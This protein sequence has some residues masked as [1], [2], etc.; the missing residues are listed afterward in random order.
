MSQIARIASVILLITLI[1]GCSTPEATLGQQSYGH[2]A[3]WPQWQGPTRDARSADTGLLKKWPEAGPRLLWHVDG[4]GA[5]YSSPTMA[6]GTI[7]ISGMIDKEGFITAVTMDGEVRWRKP[8]GPEW[9]RNYPGA[10][11]SV[12]IAD[13]RLF[14]LSGTGIAACLDAFTG[15]KKWTVDVVKSHN[16]RH[17]EWGYGESLLVV[18]SKV[19][20]TTG[21]RDGSLAALSVDDGR[22]LWKTDALDAKASYSSPIAVRRAGKDM[23][24]QLLF[25]SL[26]VVDA[27]NGSLMC[28]YDLKEHQ[29]TPGNI[30]V[31]ENTN[32]P[33]YEDGDIFVTSGY[34]AGS[35]KLRLSEDGTKLTKV[36]EN[37]DLDVH[38]GGVVLV[39]GHVYGTSWINNS[40]GRWVCVDWDT[41]ETR[42]QY[43]WDG[44]KGSIGYADG[45]LYCYREKTGMLALVTPGPQAF[46]VVSS[47]SV[48]TAKSPRHWAHPVICGGT[49]Y[50][51]HGDVLMAFDLSLAVK[52]ERSIEF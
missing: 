35:V 38:H 33:L 7:Y 40:R 17:L 19:I 36:W 50:V 20:C 41:G 48:S 45:M 34:D 52:S 32:T 11:A 3:Y 18:G 24:I 30:G 6:G 12:T 21:S 28:T 27:D 46:D 2:E 51:R 8:Y 23:I 47:F 42:Y 22:L 43:N 44:E 39:D 37:H 9:Y 49:L 29:R 5:G 4:I 16:G 26:V 15:Q 13:D 31:A 14:I 10:R 25:Q 1:S